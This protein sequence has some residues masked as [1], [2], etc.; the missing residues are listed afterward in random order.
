MFAAIGLVRR[1]AFLG[2]AAALA[3]WLIW[4]FAW[5]QR[6][7][8]SWDHPKAGPTDRM[9]QDLAARDAKAA[10]VLQGLRAHSDSVALDAVLAAEERRGGLE[11]IRRFAQSAKPGA[12][13][14]ALR[15]AELAL[16]AKLN[17]DHGQREGVL[18]AHGPAVEVLSDADAGVD[19]YLDQLEKASK[20]P[21]AWS[22]VRD[23]PTGLVVWMHV[24]DKALVDYYARERDWLAP[25]L[26]ESA[27]DA[28]ALT[29]CLQFA[30]EY[31]PLVREALV[32]LT[33]GQPLP[34][35][36]SLGADGRR[37]QE[38]PAR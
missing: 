13:P 27:G 30:Q 8:A 32:D 14:P 9:L 5:S 20:D 26:A 25:A 17:I 21:A 3:A 38:D 10:E 2:A 1:A 4:G 11:N 33:L 29:R 15:L 23:D 34:R 28:G 31:H 19:E 18:L 12:K 35:S 24:K 36:R 22:L 37:Q 7:T 6:W 16:N